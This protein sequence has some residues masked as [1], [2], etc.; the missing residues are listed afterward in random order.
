[1]ENREIKVGG[2]RILLVGLEGSW[3]LYQCLEVPDY[4]RARGYQSIFHEVPDSSI[5]IAS[6]NSPCL[7]PSADGNHVYVYVWGSYEDVDCLPMVVNF[8]DLPFNT[9]EEFAIE[10]EATLEH[11]LESLHED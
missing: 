9:I 1:M 11:V 3:L 4:M 7:L 6:R 5:T 10:L 8:A 2:F